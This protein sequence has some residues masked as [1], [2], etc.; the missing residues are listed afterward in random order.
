MNPDDFRD[1]VAIVGVG[2]TPYGEMYRTRDPLRTPYSLGRDAFK[3][4]LDDSGLTKDDID[5]VIVF[6]IPNYAKMCMILGLQHPR[7]TYPIPGQG[8]MAG[9]A[10]QLAAMAIHTGMASTVACIYGN[11]GRSAGAMYG[12]EVEAEGF[13]SYG[14]PYGMTS[15]GA[16]VAMMW[17]RY[18]HEFNVGED[19]MGSL[20]ITL[21]HHASLN[22]DA[23]MRK[24]L[25]IEEYLKARYVCYPLRLFDYCMINDGGVCII[26]TNAERARNC[27]NPPV[28]ITATAQVDAH[29]PYHFSPTYHRELMKVVADEV[30]RS[31]CVGPGDIDCLQVYDN[32]LPVVLFTLEG[33]GFCRKGTAAQW[34]QGGRTAIG[35]ELP[36]N[37]SGGQCSESYMQGWGLLVEAVRQLRG[38]CGSRQV[39]GCEVVQFII[40]GP[41]TTSHILRR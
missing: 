7:I 11:D 26:L 13:E 6:R 18:M 20:A 40:A 23:V 21:R 17:Q 29:A 16:P 10:L 39:E 5:G 33:F 31:A 37:T 8:R 30:Y 36:V 15:P 32:F 9:A 28:Y 3:K 34:I 19:V 12:A 24:S 35:G 1:K 38:Q 41:I 2:N 27:K 22:P 14:S 4:A 25:T